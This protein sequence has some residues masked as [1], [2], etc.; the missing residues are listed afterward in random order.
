MVEEFYR[1]LDEGFLRMTWSSSGQ[2]I[3]FYRMNS[4]SPLLLWSFVGCYGV[5]KRP[6]EAGSIKNTRWMAMEFFWIMGTA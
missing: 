3:G 5:L 2:R 6:Q 4:V 1:M